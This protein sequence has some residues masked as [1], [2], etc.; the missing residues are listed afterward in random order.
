MAD[1][2]GWPPSSIDDEPFVIYN[3]LLSRSLSSYSSSSFSSPSI[4]CLFVVHSVPYRC[5][6]FPRTKTKMIWI[7]N[8]PFTSIPLDSLEFSLIGSKSSSSIQVNSRGDLTRPVHNS[9]A[10][11]STGNWTRPH[12]IFQGFGA[13]SCSFELDSSHCNFRLFFWAGFVEFRLHTLNKILDTWKE[14]C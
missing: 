6:L 10:A 3:Q 11:K 2:M 7:R 12:I 14:L 4:H 5:L 8:P 13:V 1:G 9:W